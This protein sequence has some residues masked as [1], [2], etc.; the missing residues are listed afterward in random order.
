[1]KRLF[2]ACTAALMAV[3]LAIAGAAAPASAVGLQAVLCHATPPSTAANGWQAMPPLDMHAI[4]TQGHDLH[5]ADIIPAFGSYPGK[6]LTAL[7]GWGATGAQVLANGCVL[8]VQPPPAPI[9]V[10]PPGASM[11]DECGTE[12]DLI[13]IPADGTG[14][15]FSGSGGDVY[16]TAAANYAFPAGTETEW[17]FGLT[18][19]PCVVSPGV[20]TPPPPHFTDAVCD[21]PAVL[22]LTGFDHGSWAWGDQSGDSFSGEPAGLEFG[23]PYAV[24]AVA[25]QGWVIPRTSAWSFTPVEPADCG[26]DGPDGG[27]EPNPVKVV[28]LPPTATDACG[29]D[30]D[31]VDLPEPQDGVIYSQE[32]SGD[33]TGTTVVVVTATALPG[34]TLGYEGEEWATVNWDFP[35][36]NE[37]CPL[38]DPDPVIDPDPVTDPD[39][40]I[41]PDPV[42]DPGPGTDPDPVTDPDPATDPPT[43]VDIPVTDPPTGVLPQAAPAAKPAVTPTL[44]LASA[45]VEA[46]NMGLF[47]LLFFLAGAAVLVAVRRRG[48]KPAPMSATRPSHRHAEHRRLTPGE[49]WAHRRH[50][51]ART[52]TGHRH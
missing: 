36:N 8:P 35:V 50:L 46:E 41:D 7:F 49:V 48:A 45:G 14:Y 15:S 4:I 2:A 6:N 26:G 33:G 47:A 51:G 11:V 39:P 22:T 42:T 5:E 10:T 3:G 20:L 28:P 25:D 40:V 1:M 44:V 27:E 24:T 12:N 32:R 52:G 9:V 31:T 16:L 18:D 37:P 38:T 17:H 30:N 34:F 19:V 13:V 43:V 29:P 23:V 21:A